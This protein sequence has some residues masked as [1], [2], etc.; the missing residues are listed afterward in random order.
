MLIQNNTKLRSITSHFLIKICCTMLFRMLLEPK[1]VFNGTQGSP[2]P[3]LGNTAMEPQKYL[4]K[5]I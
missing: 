5:V 3:W 4:Q 1:E 2:E